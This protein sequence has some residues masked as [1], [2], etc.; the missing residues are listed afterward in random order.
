MA[1]RLTLCL[2]ARNEESMLPGCLA[3]AAGA[4]DEVVLVDTGSTDRTREI[5]RSAGATVLERAWDDDFA[6]PRNLAIEQAH[7]D[8][9]LVLD[10]D[11]RLARGAGQVIRQALRRPAFDMG[12]LRFH[13]A[14]RG[15]AGLDDVVGGAARAGE[16]YS[17]PRLLRR[18]PDLRYRGIIHENV[19]DWAA[20]HGNRYLLLPADVVHLGYVGELQGS[21]AKRDRNLALLRRRMAQ[22]PDDIS[23]YG[24][25]AQELFQRGELA[26]AEAVAARAWALVPTQPR[27][28]S[29]RRVVLVRATMAV[30][31]GQPEVAL[32]ALDEVER[33]EATNP[34]FALLRGM[35]E[36]VRAYAAPS[37]T[38]ARAAGLEAAVGA[39]RG[40]LQH[41]ADRQFLQVLL[42]EVPLGLIRLGGSLLALGRHAEA[43]EAFVKAEHASG[44]PEATVGRAEAMVRQGDAT[45]ALAL[46]EPLLRD[47]PEPWLVAAL[48]ASALGSAGDARLFLSR[49]TDLSRAGYTSP[50][51][52]ELHRELAARLGGEA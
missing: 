35:A 19:N 7:G 48:A 22:E 1:V 43:A 8:W 41:L 46:L 17:L 45:A 36:E 27:H 29:L 21:M 13:N 49:A 23:A 38:A 6:A 9:V 34:D 39:Y 28:R 2:I 42:M 25:V 40:A 52:R 33:R 18:L 14:S 26:E 11:E 30:Q 4:V 47:R 24:Y 10:A 32:E 16:P 3:A 31:R 20:A 12:F 51:Y 44:G 37:G 15:D 5:A 50:H